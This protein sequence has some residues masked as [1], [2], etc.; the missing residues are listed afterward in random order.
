MCHILLFCYTTLHDTKDVRHDTLRRQRWFI[1]YSTMERGGTPR[2]AHI[3]ACRS[4]CLL[5]LL[6]SIST[7]SSILHDYTHDRCAVLNE[8]AR[9]CCIIHILGR[10]ANKHA[11]QSFTKAHSLFGH[12]NTHVPASLWVHKLYTYIYTQARIVCTY[13]ASTERA[14]THSCQRYFV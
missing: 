14:S 5:S 6:I 7:S 9:C 12:G 2:I 10:D 4:P 3:F 8:L 11:L 13:I 1:G